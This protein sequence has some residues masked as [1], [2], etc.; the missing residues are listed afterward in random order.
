MGKKHSTSKPRTN[1]IFK[2]AGAHFKD[3]KSNKPKEV[4]SKLKTVGA[5]LLEL[6]DFNG[7]D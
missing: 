3:K 4:T 7:H 6:I 1:Q 2:I 5:C